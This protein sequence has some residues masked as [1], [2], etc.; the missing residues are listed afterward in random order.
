M[1]RKIKERDGGCYHCDCPEE[2]WI[3]GHR[4]SAGMGGSKDATCYPNVIVQCAEIN[5]AIESS[6][7]M[8]RFARDMGWKIDR[9]SI[10]TPEMIPI[11]DRFGR[12]WWLLDNGTRLRASRGVA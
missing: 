3:P 12:C 10:D 1:W 8:A 9:N 7:I 6:A 4:A 2:Y 11:M 5:G